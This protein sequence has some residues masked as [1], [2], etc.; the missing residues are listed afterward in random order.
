MLVTEGLEEKIRKSCKLFK[1][2]EWSGVLFYT[3]DGSFET[4]DIHIKALDYFPMDIGTS[5]Y[6]EFEQSPDV[7]G[8]MIDNPGLLGSNMGLIH[9]HNKMSAFFSGTDL[10]TLQEEGYHRNHFVSLIVNNEGEYTAAITR[11]LANTI[12]QKVITTYKTF[13]DEEIEL[14]KTDNAMEEEILYNILEVTIEN[15]EICEKDPL[16]LRYKEIKEEKDR[17]QEAARIKALNNTSRTWNPYNPNYNSPSVSYNNTYN[18]SWFNQP[19][20]KIEEE[21]LLFED[22]YF[23]PVKE[24]D[25]NVSDSE[26]KL[27]AAKLVKANPVF[28]LS[29]GYNLDNF[30]K[31]DMDKEM[32]RLFKTSKG[33]YEELINYLSEYLLYSDIGVASNEDLDFKS[34][35]LARGVYDYLKAFSNPYVAVICNTI[36]NYF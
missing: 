36:K 34:T 19:Q 3:V 24:V 9:S 26:I 4:K 2:K 5:S 14:V 13:G 18:A 25:L 32:T 1:D 15:N 16:F 17:K 23:L 11:K 12:I 21:P 35:V 30:I 22:D 10:N 31:E 8:Y 7:V 6:T 28:E 27:V 33:N 29:K 20:T